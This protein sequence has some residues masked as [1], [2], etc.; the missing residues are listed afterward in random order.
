MHTKTNT[1][2][3]SP[4]NRLEPQGCF[5]GACPTAIRRIS[6]LCA[7]V[8]A[9]LPVLGSAQTVT[10]SGG[11][12]TWTQPDSDSWTSATYSSGNTAVFAGSGV[13]T[14]TID[15]G[16][17]TPGQVNVTAGSYTFT[18]GGIGGSGGI[19]KSGAGTLTLSAA[20]TYTGSTSVTAGVLNIQNATALG[21][22]AAGTVVSNLAALQLQ[23]GITVSGET[24]SLA[25]SGISSDGALRNISG[26]NVW[27]GAVNVTLSGSV[28]QGYLGALTH[29]RSEAGKLTIS[30]AVALPVSATGTGGGIIING[31]GN[32]EISGN[33][34]GGNAGVLSVARNATGS[35]TWTLSGS[36]SYLGLTAINTNE[37][38][39]SGGFAI[40][41]TSL[42]YLIGTGK[43]TLQASETIGSLTSNTTSS[44]V[45]LNAN[46]LTIGADNSNPT[47]PNGFTSYQ[48]SIIG[49]GGIAKVGTGL[50]ALTGSSSFS[51]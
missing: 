15:A 40:P 13:G 39:A 9:S 49:T 46:T 10:W 50:L 14:V 27:S 51:G 3:S 4:V 23:G 1:P 47:D 19:A 2:A 18:G 33:I 32:G 28:S 35:G 29:I 45:S 6:M 11:N 42:T 20:N 5:G 34:T 36:N 16:G 17:V 26:T 31:N 21:G 30:G 43:L 22:T 44:V 12:T 25:G 37:V 7:V 48:G 41:D 8:A 38:I 24:L